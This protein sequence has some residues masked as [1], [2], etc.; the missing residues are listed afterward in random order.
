M[1]IVVKYK[2]YWSDSK[3]SINSLRLVYIPNEFILKIFHI[4]IN[5]QTM[6]LLNL[7]EM[8]ILN[9]LFFPDLSSDIWFRIKTFLFVIK[10]FGPLPWCGFLTFLWIE[11]F[12]FCRF[13]SR[14]QLLSIISL[15]EFE[16]ECDCAGNRCAEL[17]RGVSWPRFF[18]FHFVVSLSYFE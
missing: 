1:S 18:D 16:F 4:L 17:E 15:F 3:F 5:Q 13:W 8:Q 2:F 6:I 14:E 11:I 10:P 12:V 9:T 7:S